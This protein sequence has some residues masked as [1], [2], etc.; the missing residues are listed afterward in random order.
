MYPEER[1]KKNGAA[2][3]RQLVNLHARPK[4]TNAIDLGLIPWRCLVPSTIFRAH[5]LR[6][7]IFHA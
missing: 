2:L 5:K 6:K 4:K 1:F 3:A 7:K